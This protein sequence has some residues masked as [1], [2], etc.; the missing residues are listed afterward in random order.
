MIRVII[1]GPA[2]EGRFHYR[3]DTEG[4]RLAGPLRGLSAVPIWDACRRLM[5]MGA[6]DSMAEISLWRETGTEQPPEFEYSTTVGFGSERPI[7][8]TPTGPKFTSETEKNALPS[9]E[10]Q[11]RSEEPPPPLRKSQV[12]PAAAGPVH[13][14][15]DR[16]KQSRPKR[17]LGASGA[18]RGRR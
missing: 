13:P 14:A 4:T 16:P 11:A 18:R 6:A 3:I 9:A 2:R 5:E 8:E 1:T 17:K 7:E 10:T 15:P 12:P